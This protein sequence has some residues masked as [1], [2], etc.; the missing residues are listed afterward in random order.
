MDTEG[1]LEF[2]IEWGT[3]Q[4]LPVIL[5]LIEKLAEYEKLS[6]EVSATEERLRES[7]FG[8]HPSAEVLIGYADGEPVGFA[9]FFQ[10]YSTF[11]AQPGLVPGGSLCD[12]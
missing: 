10:N 8:R 12:A 3:E 7:L 2:R 11:L 5:R 1:R 9:V 4:D 6:G